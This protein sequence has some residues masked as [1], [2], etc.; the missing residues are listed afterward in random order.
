M[1]GASL[2]LIVPVSGGGQRR[3]IYIEGY[4]PRPGEDTELNTNVVGPDFF[5]TMG[6]PLVRGRAFDG[7]DRRGAPGVVVVNEEFARRYYPGQ[8]AVGKRLRTE[9]DGPSLEIVG[10][11]RTA[12][13]RSLRE[14]PLPFIYL[15]LAQD[16]QPGMTLMVRTEGDPLEA[17]AGVRAAAE[18]V[19]KG[20]PLFNV[21]TM[22]RHVGESLAN[23]RLVAVLL[24]I[25]GGVALLLAVV[26]IYGVVSY[27][28]ARRTH[29]IGVRLAL[30]AQPADI[31]SL[32]VRQGMAPVVVG[33]VV[34]LAA[35]FALTRVASGLLFGVSA[36][37]P[38]TFAGVVSLLAGVAL[39]ACYIPARRAARVDP[40]LA[41]RHE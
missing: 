38:L 39:V 2:T 36:T 25:F 7:R 23:D 13:Y 31:L 4:E 28:V 9:S 27:A 14:P 34:G 10:V 37:D 8:E 24:G 21:T 1:R 11:A 6:I 41:L 40:L 18:G 30:G 26:G 33:G 3:G 17:V 12:R 22:A 15:P 16:Y 19:D 32:V 20:V 5:Q 35:A 29:E